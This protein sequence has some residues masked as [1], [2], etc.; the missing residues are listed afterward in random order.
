MHFRT[1]LVRDEEF[2]LSQELNKLRANVPGSAYD[3]CESREY[4]QHQVDGA[5]LV[6]LGSS[7]ILA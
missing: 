3:E 2:T 6:W 1:F 4:A 5:F 7:V